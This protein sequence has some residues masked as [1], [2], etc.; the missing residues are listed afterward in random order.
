MTN[1]ELVTAL[2][3]EAEYCKAIEWDIPI[4]TEDHIRLA[5]DVIEQQDVHLADLMERYVERSDEKTSALRMWSELKEAMERRLKCTNDDTI[6]N[7]CYTDVL[8]TMEGLEN[9]Y[10]RMD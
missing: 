6:C 9:Y 4:C 5:A 8:L 7:A 3:E 2:R 1:E 10:K